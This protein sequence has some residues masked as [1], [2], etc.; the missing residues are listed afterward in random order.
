MNRKHRLEDKNI[1]L[2]AS[3]YN[4]TENKKKSESEVKRSNKVQ[5]YSQ[6]V[7]FLKQHLKYDFRQQLVKLY[8]TLQIEYYR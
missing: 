3:H 2:N 6:N 4:K 5:E 1:S 8:I 7:K